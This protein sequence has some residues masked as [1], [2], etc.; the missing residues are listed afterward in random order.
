MRDSAAQKQAI[1]AGTDSVHGNSEWVWSYDPIGDWNK[2]PLV[3][4][5]YA[6]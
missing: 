2:E 5:D 1:A 4:K 6:A 3:P